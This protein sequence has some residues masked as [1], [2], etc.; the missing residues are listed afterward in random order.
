MKLV[1]KAV[2]R[3]A[4]TGSEGAATLDHELWGDAM[5]RQSVEKW[6]LRFLSRLWI[7]EF[8]GALSEA[9]KIFDGLGRFFFKKA[10]DD[11]ALRSFQNGVRSRRA[12]QVWL[13]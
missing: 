10:A 6:A 7:G 5:K 3:P 12:C 13:L 11:L 8:L 9:D 4:S 1:G 2:A